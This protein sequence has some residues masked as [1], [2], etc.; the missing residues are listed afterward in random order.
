MEGWRLRLINKRCSDEDALNPKRSACR[1]GHAELPEHA[2]AGELGY[3]PDTE[4]LDLGLPQTLNPRR[5]APLQGMDLVLKRE[6]P[7]PPAD[8][9]MKMFNCLGQPAKSPRS[10]PRRK[11][12]HRMLFSIRN[13]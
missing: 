5:R 10:C 9:T 6:N 2:Y 8:Q 11:T 4:R 1:A 3:G 13:P 12:A 7:K